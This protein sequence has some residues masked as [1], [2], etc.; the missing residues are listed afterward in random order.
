MPSPDVVDQFELQAYV[1]GRSHLLLRF[2]VGLDCS[3]GAA[4]T[5]STCLCSGPLSASSSR[6]QR[7]SS[8]VSISSRICANRKLVQDGASEETESKDA[9]LRKL[10][11]SLDYACVARCPQALQPVLL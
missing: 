9:A 8:E 10:G 3:A 6:F 1:D 11:Y 5:A 4:S 2:R 7:V